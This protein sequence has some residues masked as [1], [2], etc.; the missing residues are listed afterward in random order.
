MRKTETRYYH[1]SEL[2]DSCKE[3]VWDKKKTMLT[4]QTLQK[5]MRDGSENFIL[6]SLESP[7]SHSVSPLYPDLRVRYQ[8][9]MPPSK[10]Y[11]N[12]LEPG[13]QCVLGT[14]EDIS[15]AWSLLQRSSL[16]S[17]VK[18]NIHVFFFGFSSFQTVQITVTLSKIAMCN[19]EIPNTD[20]KKQCKSKSRSMRGLGPNYPSALQVPLRTTIAVAFPLAHLAYPHRQKYPCCHRLPECIR[21]RLQLTC[22][23]TLQ[24]VPDEV[25]TFE[26]GEAIGPLLWS[27]TWRILIFEFGVKCSSVH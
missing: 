23:T 26:M 2:Q 21:D 18:S 14:P 27:S 11:Y 19:I 5:L 17:E 9:D 13:R 25:W 16:G 4:C 7:K 6:A 22:D 3:L 15:S 20:Q 1:I 24:M 12:S 8:Q 10:I